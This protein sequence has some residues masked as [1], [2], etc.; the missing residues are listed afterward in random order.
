MQSRQRRLVAMAVFMTVF[1]F[2]AV[3]FAQPAPGPMP[4]PTL[5]PT[6]AVVTTLSLIAGILTNWI[7]SGTLLGRW[8]SPKSWLPDMTMISTALG[9]FLGYT[10]SQSP[11]TFS[12]TNL[13]Y[14]AVAAVTALLVGAAPSA[15]MH[16]HSTLPAARRAML[17]AAA[18][19]A[20]AVAL[21]GMLVVGQTACKGSAL[22]TI[23]AVVQIVE[24]DLIA[25]VGDAQLSSDVCKALGGTAS[26]DAICAAVPG[27]IQDAITLLIDAGVLPPSALATAQTY[28]T[29]HPKAPAASTTVSK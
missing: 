14:G 5:T 23:A 13:F 22:P 12:G 1:V 10:T 26:T 20:A 15:A 19:G 27:L 3:A 28:M 24:A 11:V 7:Q 2:T 21:I 16:A 6:V 17:A 9:G 18:K 8:I 25:N 29:A 4:A